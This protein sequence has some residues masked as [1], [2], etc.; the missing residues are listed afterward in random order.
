MKIRTLLTLLTLVVLFLY[1]TVATADPVELTSLN[2]SGTINGALFTNV[3]QRQPAG[4]GAIHSFVR[5][6]ANDTEQGYN[7]SG[8]PLGQPDVNTSLTF[9]HDLQYGSIPTVSVSGVAYK[10]FLLDINEQSNGNNPYLNLHNVQIRIGSTGSVT[11]AFGAAH[12]SLIYDMDA[13]PAG[14][15]VVNLK[16]GFFPGSGESDMFMYVPVSKFSGATSSTYVYLYSKFGSPP[17][18]AAS[19]DGFEEWAVGTPTAVV[20]LPA[21]AW[22]G[23]TLLGSTGLV[24]VIRRR[25]TSEI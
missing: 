5:I 17:P 16:Y 4:S 8:R 21:A 14:D 2:S 20:P 25:T 15:S 12:G 1:Q 10:E 11:G 7:T 3:D 24:S 23:M 9:T 19:G 13:A 18:S 6:Q 22:M